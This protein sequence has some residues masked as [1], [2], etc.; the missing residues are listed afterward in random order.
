MINLKNSEHVSALVALIA[1]ILFAFASFYDTDAET[2]LFPRIIAVVL[3]IL[4][5]T[6]FVSDWAES[7]TEDRSRAFLRHVWPGLLIGL[8]YLLVMESL[9]F[10]LS[11]WLAF[12]AVILAYGGEQP[13]LQPKTV[14]TKAAVSAGFMVILYLLFWNGLNVRTP[15]GI[16]F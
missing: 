11:S 2:Y 6:L 16:L 4:S 15:T 8:V 12:L 14:L 10:Y 1:A 9:G 7:E 13:I 3:A 5:L